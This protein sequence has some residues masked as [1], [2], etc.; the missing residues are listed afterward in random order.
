M[1]PRGS[2][3]PPRRGGRRI[4]LAVSFVTIGVVLALVVL[5]GLGGF[6]IISGGAARVLTNT[7]DLPKEL[8]LC[9]HF[10]PSRML[11][12]DQGSKKRYHVEGDCPVAQFELHDS[13]IADLEYAGWTVHADSTGNL[14]AYRYG[15]R[16]YI[17]IVFSESSATTN[18]TSL[19]VDM[20]TQTDPAPDFPQATP[21]KL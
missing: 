3:I 8:V 12:G 6:F 11:E 16:E 15:F 5:L 1:Q 19:V 7:S 10:Q 17:T 2:A 18:A 4:L 21:T 14:S 9:E 13:Y 20:Y